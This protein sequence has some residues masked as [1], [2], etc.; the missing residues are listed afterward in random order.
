MDDPREEIR[1]GRCLL[2]QYVTMNRLCRKCRTPLAPVEE[3]EAE[4]IM[5]I[6]DTFRPL[7][8][9]MQFQIAQRVRDLRKLR[10]KNQR[11]IASRMGCARTYISKI[12]NG[13]ALPNIK[14]IARFAGAFNITAY[15]FMLTAEEIRR[16]N[17]LADPFIG[18]LA[19]DLPKL[20]KDQRLQVLRFADL[21]ERQS[22]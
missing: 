6:P 15:E 19:A 4:P 8:D 18:E 22:V 20:S 1:C 7:G 12:E 14:Q 21:L 9:T 11:E 3:I 10:G 17:F 16:Q 5:S 2:N 13:F